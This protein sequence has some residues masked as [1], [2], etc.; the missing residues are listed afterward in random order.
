M[1]D[2]EL[3]PPSVLREVL[4]VARDV[5]IH[6][7]VRTVITAV[8][9]WQDRTVI[10]AAQVPR[11][12]REPGKASELW[13]LGDDLGTVYTFVGGGGSGSL[14]HWDELSIFTPSIPEGAQLLE[15]GVP[16]MPV[17]VR[18]GLDQTVRAPVN[19]DH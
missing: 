4:A 16:G 14:T 2:W 7:G 9:V 8:E 5:G 6:S 15:V 10:H 1:D 11:P 12:D 17:A 18:I 13:S 19:Y 3:P